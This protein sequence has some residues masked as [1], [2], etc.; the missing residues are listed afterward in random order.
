MC[1]PTGDFFASLP[2]AK[3]RATRWS[4]KEEKPE[5]REVR[6][7]YTL[8]TWRVSREVYLW[9]LSSLD[10]KLLVDVRGN[11]KAGREEQLFK[12]KDFTKAL[13]SIGVRYEWWGDRL[14]EEQMEDVEEL[15]CRIKGLLASACPGAICIFGHMHEPHKCHR[16]QLC[17]LFPPGHA[18][19]HLMWQDHRQIKMLSHVDA[20]NLYSRW[21]TYFNDSMAREKQKR[22]ERGSARWRCGRSKQIEEVLQREAKALPVLSWESTSPSDW[23]EKLRDGKAYRLKLPWDTE[24]LW[25]PHFMSETEADELEETIGEKITMYHPT[26]FFQTPSGVTQETVNRKGQARICDDFNF[27]IQYDNSRDKSQLYVSEKMDSWSRALMH[28]VEHASESVFN[29]IWF[30]HYRDGTVT[31][32]WHSDGNEGLGPDPIIASLSLGATRDFAFKSKRE[33]RGLRK[34]NDG[35]MFH[36]NNIIHITLP[37]FHGS[38]CVMGKNS[39]RH[40]L[41]AVPAMEGIHRERTNLTFRFWA[42]E[43]FETIDAAEAQADTQRQFRLRLTPSQRLAQRR[44]RPVILDAPR[45]A[46]TTVE[47]ML[48]RLENLLPPGLGEVV[49]AQTE[50]DILQNDQPLLDELERLGLWPATS[51][52]PIINLQLLPVADEEKSGEC[53]EEVS[54][55]LTQHSIEADSAGLQLVRE[56]QLSCPGAYAPPHGDVEVQ[57]N[58][59]S[60]WIQEVIQ[61]LSGIQRKSKGKGRIS[62]MVYHQC[63]EFCALYLARP[64]SSVHLVITPKRPLRFCDLGR[65]EAPLLRRLG[66]YGRLLTEFLGKHAFKVGVQTR[67]LPRDSQVF[68]H[69]LSMDLVAPDLNDLTRRHFLEF[70]TGAAHGLIALEDLA[71]DLDT[72]DVHRRAALPSEEACLH[73]HRCGQLFGDS[74]RQLLLHL[75][76]CDAPEAGYA[77]AGARAASAGGLAVELL[78]EMGFCCGREV[79]IEL[80]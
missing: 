69:V 48:R 75:R 59:A 25:Y 3:P 7:V 39:Q 6:K 40:W 24:L 1:T 31:I 4:R 16:L 64:K 5:G 63:S 22:C 8:G 33:W 74:M 77:E 41:H 46:K 67:K 15:R 14:G 11:P 60:H 36:S 58:G 28:R 66:L 23:E 35:S 12:G 62:Q 73:C 27:G 72:G 55:V 29:A 38:L 34:A 9:Q 10:V 43:G 49:L 51:A 2:D 44:A 45:D 79:R 80:T 53:R 68:A 47:E 70:T 56:V 32:H 76:R 57:A 61:N 26:Y 52:M 54:P 71:R 20:S 30:N 50:G 65:C 19:Q 17:D 21:V 37:L 42:L 18:I 78:E 13:L